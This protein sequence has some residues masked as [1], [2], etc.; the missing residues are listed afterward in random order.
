MSW[1]FL[2]FFFLHSP[3]CHLCVGTDSL[4]CIVGKCLSCKE[5]KGYYTNKS[6]D[7]CHV[8]ILHIN[9][10]TASAVRIV[11]LVIFINLSYLLYFSDV[12]GSHCRDPV[13][14]ASGPDGSL[15]SRSDALLELR[16]IDVIDLPLFVLFDHCKFYSTLRAILMLECHDCLRTA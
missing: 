11:L 14:T 16:H 1:R 2:C 10:M 8:F 7:C 3:G 9:L 6:Y 13:R 5:Y 4:E 15:W 12:S